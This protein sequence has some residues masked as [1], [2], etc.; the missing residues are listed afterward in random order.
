VIVLLSGC[1]S[2]GSTSTG[3]RA[4][5]T[6]QAALT[7]TIDGPSAG[8]YRL[9]GPTTTPAGMTRISLRNRAAEPH[10]AQLVKVT[11][12]PTPDDVTSALISRPD[13]APEGSADPREAAKATAVPAWLRPAGGP[14][15]TDPGEVATVT[16]KLTPGEYRIVDVG[17][18]A[19][20]PEQPPYASR[21][22]R[23]T[24]RVV[25]ASAASRQ[26]PATLPKTA[27]VITAA[28]YTFQVRGRLQRGT[29]RVRFVNA[30]KQMH[31]LVATRIRKGNGLKEVNAFIQFDADLSKPPPLEPEFSTGST[32]LDAGLSQVVDLNLKAGRYA[33]FCFMGDRAGGR[34][35][36]QKGMIAEVAIK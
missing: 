21:G 31:H 24:L 29:N 5:D 10:E 3:G 14:P 16:T 33:L 19:D 23:T 35:H 4:S 17:R 12:S 20:Q 13:P 27:G 11:G 22:A 6:Q 30:G 28:E 34:R 26:P 25:E 7:Y 32:I 8:R 18:P 2:E 15:L 9:T 36:A 1:A